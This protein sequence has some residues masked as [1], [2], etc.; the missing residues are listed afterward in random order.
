MRVGARLNL[1]SSTLADYQ[2]MGWTSD[3]GLYH[4]SQSSRYRFALVARNIGS[5]FTTYDNVK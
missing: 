3:L 5:Q 4:E 2:S 1:V